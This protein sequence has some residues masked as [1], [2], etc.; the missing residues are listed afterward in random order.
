MGELRKRAEALL[1]PVS[2]SDALLE[3]PYLAI[4]GEPGSGKST[5][6]KFCAHWISQR[7]TE[8]LIPILLRL[9]EYEEQL[10]LGPLEVSLAA[11]IDRYHSIGP[12]RSLGMLKAYQRDGRLAI[13]LDGMDEVSEQTRSNI[14]AQIRK[15]AQPGGASAARIVVTSRPVGFRTL[16]PHI[17]EHALKPLESRDEAIKY[18]TLWLTMLRKLNKK[19]PSGSEA[20]E[21]KEF[22]NLIDTQGGLRRIVDNPLLLRIAVET[23]DESRE[24]VSERAALYKR[25]IEEHLWQRAIKRGA[26]PILKMACLA[27]L[28]EIAWA[29]QDT[30]NDKK[31]WIEAALLE[32]AAKRDA[33]PLAE[34]PQLLSVL[35]EKLGLLVL[36]GA[37][38]NPSIAFTRTTFQEY[39]VARRLAAAWAG[40]ES[41]TWAGLRK[42]LHYST[43]WRESVLLTANL[44]AVDH[45]S[46]LIGRILRAHS[47]Y[48]R[49][50]F[51]DLT[52][53]AD[54]IAG[55][56]KVDDRTISKVVSGAR[57]IFSPHRSCLA[58]LGTYVSLI[59]LAIAILPWWAALLAAG[60]WTSLWVLLSR[61]AY[62]LLRRFL[63]LPNRLIGG[64]SEVLTEQIGIDVLKAVANNEAVA[65]LCE[66]M[67][68]GTSV[69]KVH[70]ARALGE[71]RDPGSVPAL[72]DTLTGPL[73]T[74]D[75]DADDAA[76]KI[77]IIEVM[78]MHRTLRFMPDGGMVS[79]P[80]GDEYM[81]L[82]VKG[83]AARALGKIGD[84]S[85]LPALIEA[86]RHRITN[87]ADMAAD[88]L[89]AIGQID[90]QTLPSLILAASDED[91][92][93]AELAVRALGRM[94]ANEAD[95]ISALL[96]ALFRD[97]GDIAEAAAEALGSI[98]DQSVVPMIYQ[99]LASDEE[100]MGL[101][102][103][104]VA[105]ALALCGDPAGIP[106]LADRISIYGDFPSSQE[107]S[108]LDR[109]GRPAIDA[110]LGM[111]SD[112]ERPDQRLAAIDAL[113]AL[114]RRHRHG[115]GRDRHGPV[116]GRMRAD[117]DRRAAQ[118]IAELGEAATDDDPEVRAAVVRALR[119][120][121]NARSAGIL[122]NLLMSEPETETRRQVAWTLV[123]L[124]D[125]QALPE[126]SLV[127][128]R[129]GEDEKVREAAA[130]GLGR[131]GGEAELQLFIGLLEEE[132]SEDVRAAIIRGL[133]ELGD[134][135]G[136]P[137]LIRVF[138]R[139]RNERLRVAIVKALGEIGDPAAVELLLQSHPEDGRSG[140]ILEALAKIGDNR[141][142][143]TLV[144]ALVRSPEEAAHAL[145]RF[146]KVAVPALV[147]SIRQS[148]GKAREAACMVLGDIG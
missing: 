43:S 27:A 66:L 41:V 11:E 51:R 83:E 71:I 49:E 121:R 7:S 18:V 128:R 113:G 145:V 23:Y 146:G 87:V 15:S 143:P 105:V 109:I 100:R 36:H 134:A 97:E 5:A 42:R 29:I 59:A 8:G 44:L 21:A 85:A 24:V 39:F 114:Q 135:R 30:G 88:A 67:R 72:V 47:A 28:E 120:A 90:S 99:R 79:S 106:I 25:Y 10:R 117:S 91:P 137:V 98:S 45:A 40:N 92:H 65:A 13:L 126:L 148:K 17:E 4:L 101:I 48:E 127:L 1:V 132:S 141:A 61:G 62:P 116:W 56:A 129:Q 130:A 108:A 54:A 89:I 12:E 140:P 76:K 112:R 123:E 81:E 57:R 60:A 20:E 19:D 95:V 118:V 52:L 78:G 9:K 93:V 53:A 73:L 26:P 38:S 107:I 63:L 144:A 33:V 86:L 70:V 37:R 31:D 139:E 55:G 68:R 35:T 75:R 96:D 22:L 136:A 32:A 147:E 58:L 102:R 50:L 16:G 124:G 122:R 46:R 6:L 64:P 133:G 3:H 34:V 104:S 14:Q 94:G 110:L 111:L 2:M 125:S 142:L 80:L 74:G 84:S 115:D 103:S 69:T 119:G 138:Q 82:G 77:T 131:F